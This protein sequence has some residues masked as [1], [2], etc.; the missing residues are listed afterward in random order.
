VSDVHQML[1]SDPLPRTRFSVAG[2]VP[3]RA[4]TRIRPSLQKEGLNYSSAGNL[5]AS[6]VDQNIVEGHATFLLAL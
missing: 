3:S 2:G 6:I 1:V 4:A 5:D